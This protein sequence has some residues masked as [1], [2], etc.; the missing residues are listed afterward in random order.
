ME[1][2]GEQQVEKV[3]LIRPRAASFHSP[4]HLEGTSQV[5]TTFCP[6]EAPQALPKDLTSSVLGHFLSVNFFT[7]LNTM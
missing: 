5:F 3:E 7:V 6:A 2:S 4:D 1:D